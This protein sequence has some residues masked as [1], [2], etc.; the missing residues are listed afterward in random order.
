MPL[1]PVAV[2]LACGIVLGRYVAAPLGFWAS[3]GAFALVGGW[4]S[5]R[6]RHLRLLTSGL[7]AGAIAMAGA[8]LGC[9]AWHRTADDNLAAFLP[10]DATA[11]ITLTGRVESDV[12]LGAF[13]AFGGMQTAFTLRAESVSTRQGPVPCTGRCAVTVDGPAW[14]VRPGDR[15]RIV[16][17][18]YRPYPA[19]NPGQ[20]DSLQYARLEGMPVRCRAPAPE[21][22]ERL[23]APTTSTGIAARLRG[24]ALRSLRTEGEPEHRALLHALLLG[25]RDRS[26]APT[27]RA[28]IRAGA[29]HY[30]SISGMHLGILLGFAYAMLRLARVSP[31]TSAAVVLV[32]LAAYL[33]TA[34]PRTPLL[35]A[36]LMAGAM[37][38]A[39][40]TG[41][42]ANLGNLLAGAAIVLLVVDPTELFRPAFQLSFGIV[43][44]MLVLTRPTQRLLFGRWLRRRG[45]MVFR[46][47][48]RGRRWLWYGGL[49]AGTGLLAGSLAAWLA[50]APLVAAHFGI[51]TPLAPL[52]TLALLPIVAT[53]LVVG[54][55]Q[56]LLS[57]I[58]PN[59]AGLL[60]WPLDHLAG[61]ISSTA[62]ALSRLCPLI[63]LY[64][65][66][67]WAAGLAAVSLAAA[68]NR[69]RL[70]L[71]RAW[72][73]V[74][75]LAVLTTIVAATQRTAPAGV[76]ELALLDV[77]HGQCAVFRSPAGRTYLFDAG[78]MSVREP[79]GRILLPFL[80]QVRWA[81]PSAAFISHANSDHY[82]ALPGLLERNPSLAVLLGK[83]FGGGED[84]DAS[85]QA[86]LRLLDLRAPSTR[87]LHRGHRLALDE[88]T[89]VTVLWPPAAPNDEG[90]S[91]NDRSLVLRLECDGLR[92]LLPGDIQETPQHLLSALAP[93]EIKADVLL[94]PHHGSYT[95]ALGPF[96]EAVDP[97]LVLRSSRR[98]RDGA[99]DELPD[100]ARQRRLLATDRHGCL[101]VRLSAG[102]VEARGFTSDDEGE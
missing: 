5:L 53:A 54:Y 49:N 43:A 89:M 55:A 38:A 94:L 30:L 83:S 100:L 92:V 97:A 11:L 70:Q 7:L 41:R 33:L 39:V 80:R 17:R 28:L 13:G 77:R 37:C 35:R 64:P 84:A 27:Q 18:L 57:P 88:R 66:P 3:A 58:A 16:G 2:L 42:S 62:E 75:L 63:E 10:A 99:T 79:D 85:A 73:A 90:L 48:E 98:R 4:L 72:T 93:A 52:S 26:L 51:L 61:W 19:T 29:A 76:A 32:M 56:V 65:V 36:A 68:A 96:V 34:E 102:E 91:E 50:S 67:A 21:A 71:T 14:E 86:L 6:H 25:R 46:P 101:R 40:L 24:T 87:R 23:D 20:F 59:L 78:S 9:L 8:S 69:R 22:V 47:N 45:L 31:R 95:P 74:M 44:G 1:A 15:V 82:N 60:G 81:M 12:R